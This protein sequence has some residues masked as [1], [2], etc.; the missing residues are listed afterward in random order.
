MTQHAF[1]TTLAHELSERAARACVGFISPRN[2]ALR[3]HL[4][5]AIAAPHGEPTSLLAQ[6]VFEALFEWE[7]SGVDLTSLGLHPNTVK[8]L[9]TASSLRDEQFEGLFPEGR[10]PYRHQAAAWKHLHDRDVRGVLV[11]TGT[12]SGKTESFLVP[13]IDSLARELAQQPDGAPLI[14]VRALFLYPLNALINSQRERLLASTLPFGH[15]MRFCLYNGNTPES[16]PAQE[17]LRGSEV[18]ER[19]LVRSEPPPMLITN[20]TMLEYMLVRQTDAPILTRSR[21]QLRYIVIDEAHTYLGSAAAELALLLRRVMQGF[22]ANADTVQFIATSATIGG[23]D[24]KDKL[25]TFLAQ[26]AGVDRAQVRVVDGQRVAQG[27]PSSLLEQST[28]APDSNELS[29][30]DDELLGRRLASAPTVRSVRDALIAGPRTVGSLGTDSAETLSLLDAASRAR[31]DGDPFLPLRGHFYMRTLEGI[32][33]CTNNLCSGRRGNELDVESWPWGKVFFS[34]RETCTDCD[35]VVAEQVTCRRCGEAYLVMRDEQGLLRPAEWALGA[36]LEEGDDEEVA[37]P[38]SDDDATVASAG[39]VRLLASSDGSRG[40]D[41]KP[42]PTWAYDPSTGSYGARGTTSVRFAPRTPSNG[43]RC[44]H[45]GSLHGDDRAALRRARLGVNYLLRNALWTVGEQMPSDG[46]AKSNELPAGGRRLITFTDSRQ[47][48]ARHALQSELEAEK[49]WLRASVYHHIWEHART[50]AAATDNERAELLKQVQGLESLVASNPAIVMPMLESA[51]EKLRRSDALPIPGVPW[52]VL[53]GKLQKESTHKW[54]RRAMQRSYQ[55]TSLTDEQAAELWLLREF[56]VRLPRQPSL[57]NLGLAQLTYPKLAQVAAPSTWTS[58]GWTTAEWQQL[59]VLLLD[60]FVRAQTAIDVE[61]PVTRWLGQHVFPKWIVPEHSDDLASWQ[62]AWPSAQRTHLL[63]VVRVVF[64]ALGLSATNQADREL[65]DTLLH[66]AWTALRDSEYLRQGEDGRALN[67]DD[68]EVTTVTSAMVCPVTNRV[69]SAHLR[70]LSVYSLMDHHGRCDAITLPRPQRLFG[71]DLGATEAW[72]RDDP[73]VTALR[74]RGLWTEFSDRIVRFGPVLYMASAEHSAQVPK[75]LLPKLEAEFKAGQ[76]NVLHCSTT[77]EMGVDIG[78]LSAVIMN[79]TPP[80][81]ANYMQRAGRAGR[82]GEARAVVLTMCPPT[83]H[84]HEVFAKPEW[85]FVTEVRAPEV[86]LTSERIVQRHLHSQLLSEFLKAEAHAHTM[87]CRGFFGRDAAS[88]ASAADRFCVWLR[89]LSADLSSPVI[90]RADFILRRTALDGLARSRLR[91][92]ADELEAVAARWQT[93]RESQLAELER[94]GG[95]LDKPWDKMESAERSIRLTIRRLDEDFLL[96]M[97]ATRS[98]LPAYGFP[99]SVVPLITVNGEELS[100]FKRRQELAVGGLAEDVA[101]PRDGYPTRGIERALQE[102]APGSRVLINGTVRE[103]RGVTL[104]WHVPAASEPLREPQSLRWF[105]RCRSCGDMADSLA[106]PE[107][108]PCCSLSDI[109]RVRY[110]EPAGFAVDIA[111]QPHNDSQQRHLLP[112]AE[113]RVSATGTAWSSL[114]EPSL[115]RFRHSHEGVVYSHVLGAHQRG[116]VVCRYCGRADALD[117]RDA[118]PPAFLRH[119]RLRGGRRGVDESG[120]CPGAD[121]ES[122]PWRDISFGGVRRTDVLELDLRD[123]TNQQPIG[124]PRASATAA[125]LAVALR[126][127]LARRLGIDPRELGFARRPI[128]TGDD[129][130]WL[131]ALYDRADGG[132]GYVGKALDD[133]RELFEEA[134]KVLDCP[135]Q[136]DRLCHACL[137]SFDTDRDAIELDRKLGL[138]A[139]S[140]QVM[141]ALALPAKLRAFGDATRFEPLAPKAAAQLFLQRHG[142]AEVIRAYW[143]AHAEDWSFSEWN[144]R[145]L[146]FAQQSR[147]ARIEVVA[148]RSTLAQ[149]PWDEANV[150]AGQLEASGFQLFASEEASGA[151]DMHLCLSIVAGGH[152]RTWAVSDAYACAPSEEWGLAAERD[153]GVMTQTLARVYGSTW[154]DLK[155]SLLPFAQLRKPEP[156]RAAVWEH[157][158]GATPTMNSFAS[159]LWR[160]VF[161][162]LGIGDS[163]SASALTQLSYEDRYLGSPL[164]ARALHALVDGLMPFGLARG[165]AVHIKTVATTPGRDSEVLHANFHGGGTQREVLRG[166]LSTLVDSVKVDALGHTRD[167][168]HAR[169][170]NLSWSNGTRLRLGLDQGLGFIETQRREPFETSGKPSEQVGKLLAAN[171]VLRPQARTWLWAQ[172]L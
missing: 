54:I 98:F 169:T 157:Q 12:S 75:H 64:R 108:C 67:F 142:T 69:T 23:T 134:R 155:C 18:R 70:G 25:Q 60:G 154:P 164:T 136:C 66:H 152:T 94:L 31:I 37:D 95:T 71:E 171:F 126:E 150:L 58:R 112:P 135:Q 56:A 168:G 79:N 153:A 30:D 55:P 14:G 32:W 89:D 22:E 15:R 72:L 59:L 165:T 123:M 100:D 43:L 84:A 115:G 50:G 158:L 49:T 53:R 130:G 19:R 139:L 38:L 113:N 6:P 26:L 39:E 124:G 140:D 101:D 20:A 104:N 83:S 87:S 16:L 119:R 161:A 143:G 13:I 160:D 128:G 80:A 2:D 86:A 63:N 4:L 51:R 92:A 61:R 122:R 111:D 125:T 40:M 151:P 172:R 91:V 109:V 81:P 132:A 103:P 156:L 167:L 52:R 10:V 11:R 133:V 28:A 9:R 148:P 106:K 90:E 76:I 121:P 78:G 65:V 1:F 44:G 159:E 41:G 77:M 120:P 68:V 97:L 57:E 141:D 145:P 42:T 8:A 116:Y 137:L 21:G 102:Y 163:I 46:K 144:L 138:A 36:N 34:R 114:P 149:L 146:L 29:L 166:L 85:P 170:L 96:R 131:I 24:A 129:R 5:R 93:E 33:C 7:S 162:R 99:L 73:L 110:L 105:L 74:S 147:G 48:T 62:V 35:S 47:G 27:L 45:C 88:S 107:S 118:L 17:R 127:A 3:A 117:S 82:R